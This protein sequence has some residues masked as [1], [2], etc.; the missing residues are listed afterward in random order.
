MR[1]NTLVRVVTVVLAVGVTVAAVVPA[2]AEPARDAQSNATLRIIGGP[3]FKANRSFS[4]TSRFAQDVVDINSGGRLTIRDVT[5]QEHTLSV[6]RRGQVPRNLGQVNRCFGPG[7]CDDIAVDHGAVDPETGDQQEPTE[8]LVN[9]GAAG[10][11]Q[12]G[13]SVIIPPRRKVTVRVTANK[14]LYYL[15]AIHP[16]MLGRLN[17]D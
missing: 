5:R 15:C 16:W 13:D 12:P 1:R 4:D 17:V 14:D 9:K 7:P 8:P 3:K 11:N 6:V 2:L 10:F